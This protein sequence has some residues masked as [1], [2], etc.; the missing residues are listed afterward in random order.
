MLPITII[1]CKILQ[2]MK[3]LLEAMADAAGIEEREKTLQMQSLPRVSPNFSNAHFSIPSFSSGLNLRPNSATA[4]HVR[5][6]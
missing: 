5:M 6:Q 4:S 3:E 2:P 1:A